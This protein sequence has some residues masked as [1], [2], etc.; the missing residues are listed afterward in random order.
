MN[1]KTLGILGTGHLASYTVAGL[2]N[3]QDTRPIV[4]SPRNA[5]VANKLANEFQ[6]QVAQSNQQVVDQAQI[7]LLAVR[8]HHCCALLDELTFKTGQLVISAIA[9]ITIQQLQAHPSLNNQTI[10]RT[11]PIV[12]AEVNCGPVPVFPDN[13]DVK[14]LLNGLGDVII[15]DDETQFDIATVHACMHGWIYFWLDEM[16]NWTC[17]KGIARPQAENMVKQSIVGALRI[18]DHSA[19]SLDEIGK[20]IA[21]PGT[22]TLS[23]LEQLRHSQALNYWPEAMESVLKKLQAD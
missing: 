7:V 22:Y 14:Q 5:G 13:K 16:I 12:S 9:G 11:L 18:S 10:V 8:P 17:D 23:G 1:L 4:L 3:C 6:C 20:Q 21:T 15:L 2:R 19:L